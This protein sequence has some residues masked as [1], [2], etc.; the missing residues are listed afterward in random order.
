MMLPKEDYGA[1]WEIAKA[2][3]GH[4]DM[5]ENIPI[6]KATMVICNT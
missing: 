1:I 2:S 4:K 5:E 6:T 3:N